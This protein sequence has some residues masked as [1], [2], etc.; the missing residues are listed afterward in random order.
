[1]DNRPAITPGFW[2][3]TGDMARSTAEFAARREVAQIEGR[4]GETTRRLLGM[5]KMYSAASNETDFT[6]EYWEYRLA[7]EILQDSATNWACSFLDDLNILETMEARR[8]EICEAIQ[9]EALT[10]AQA[11]ELLS[12]LAEITN[13]LALNSL[14]ETDDA[15]SIRREMKRN[16]L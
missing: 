8:D 1:M 11:N 13:Y 5:A 9:R 4:Y 16:N 10:L 15:Y 2:M 3:P 6:P 7:A 14:D 12:E